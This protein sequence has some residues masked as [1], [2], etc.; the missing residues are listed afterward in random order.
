MA[1]TPPPEPPFDRAALDRLLD[2]TLAHVVASQ[3]D[4]WLS[5]D[6]LSVLILGSIARDLR[7][8][9]EMAKNKVDA[10]AQKGRM[11]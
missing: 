11:L 7:A 5:A 1:D 6:A 4:R 9:I 3:G 2:R 10:E 8:L